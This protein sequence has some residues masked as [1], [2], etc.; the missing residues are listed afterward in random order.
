LL[1][2]IR[3]QFQLHVSAQLYGHLQADL[4]TGGV[5]DCVQSSA[6]RWPYNWDETYSWNYNL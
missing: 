6:W 3:L 5:Y 2:Y 4:W 1:D